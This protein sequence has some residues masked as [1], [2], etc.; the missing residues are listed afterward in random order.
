GNH[1]IS[2]GR[3][4]AGNHFVEEEQTGSSG[5]RASHFESL[6]VGKRERGGA[7]R[8]LVVEIEAAEDLERVRARVVDSSS[9]Q[10]RPDDDIVL[11]AEGRKGPDNLEGAADAA[12][13]NLIGCKPID[14]FAVEGDGSP[15]G[16]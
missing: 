15:V 9:M 2:L 11:D 6:A 5:K 16:R 14:A 3:H 7:L 4:Q 12:A 13:A 8:A 10:Q 1:S